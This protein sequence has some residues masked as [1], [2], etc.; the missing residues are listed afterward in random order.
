MNQRQIESPIW[1]VALLIRDSFDRYSYEY[2]P[3]RRLE[4]IE[5]D[6]QAIEKDVVSMLCEGA[7]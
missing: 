1:G 5:A 4:K 6:I 7:G 2:T 3:P